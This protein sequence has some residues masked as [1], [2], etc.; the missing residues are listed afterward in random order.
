MRASRAIRASPVTLI[1]CWSRSNLP[2]SSRPPPPRRARTRPC[3]ARPRGRAPPGTWRSCRDR[4]A[5]AG[6]RARPARRRGGARHPIDLEGPVIGIGRK[7]AW[8]RQH[9]WIPSG[10]SSRPGWSRGHPVDHPVLPARFG[11]RVAAGHASPW[12]STITFVGSRNFSTLMPAYQISIRAAPVLTA[13]NLALELEVGE[14]VVLVRPAKPV[15]ARRRR[16]AP[17]GSA[18]DASTPLVQPEVPVRGTSRDAPGSRTGGRRRPPADR[19]RARVW[20]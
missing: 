13:R 7:G 18:H 9:R 20:R 19:S 16:D 5:R 3:P 6:R 14:R 15:L 2:P 10:I 11:Q 12:R 1:R 4:S 8:L 17:R